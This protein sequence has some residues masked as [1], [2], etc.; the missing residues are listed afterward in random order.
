MKQKRY[1]Q[2]VYG[3]AVLF[4]LIVA[5]I[6]SNPVRWVKTMLLL[7]ELGFCL[8]GLIAKILAMRKD[9]DRMHNIS[10]PIINGCMLIGLTMSW[11]YLE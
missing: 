10:N 2:I 6:G 7:I 5:I 4:S 8:V 9:N 3:L 1:K 11:L